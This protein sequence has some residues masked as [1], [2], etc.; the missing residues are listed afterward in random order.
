MLT[1]L[2]GVWVT[3]SD[4]STRDPRMT[5]STPAPQPGNAGGCGHA[6]LLCYEIIFQSLVSRFF[7]LVH[8]ITQFPGM[9]IAPESLNRKFQV[10]EPSRI[11]R[12]KIFSVVGFGGIHHVA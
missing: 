6:L 12:I 10:A 1:A 7:F 3:D 8:F 4:N 9:D 11:F 5:D 2:S